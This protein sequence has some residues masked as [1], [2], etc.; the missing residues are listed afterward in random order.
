MGCISGKIRPFGRG[1]RTFLRLCREGKP[2]N[3]ELSTTFSDQ[4]VRGFFSLRK[5]HAS[6]TDSETYFLNIWL[7][8]VERL[9][10]TALAYDLA[11]IVKIRATSEAEAT[12]KLTPVLW[13][14]A[15]TPVLSHP[16]FS[17]RVF[18]EAVSPTTKPL[19]PL[20][21]AVYAGI[22][23]VKGNGKVSYQL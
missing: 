14:S 7:E 15:S 22:G 13:S 23:G 18:S 6:Q 5:D 10:V 4:Q 3:W 2:P 12:Q 1:C 19:P 17:L 20:S 21:L 11:P 16:S 9:P 8:R